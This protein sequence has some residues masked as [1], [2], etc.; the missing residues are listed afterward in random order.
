MLDEKLTE[1][2][3]K[4]RKKL[5]SL[6]IISERRNLLNTVIRIKNWMKL[7]EN[8]EASIII[9]LERYDKKDNDNICVQIGDSGTVAKDSV[10]ISKE[11]A[12]DNEALAS[13]YSVAFS[14]TNVRNEIVIVQE[15]D[16]MKSMDSFC[17]AVDQEDAKNIFVADTN[18]TPYTFGQMGGMLE[19]GDVRSGN[20]TSFSASMQTKYNNG[21]TEV[22]SQRETYGIQFA[23]H[24]SEVDVQIDARSQAK[25]TLISEEN[26]DEMVICAEPIMLIRN[27]NSI[28][29]RLKNAFK[30]IRLMS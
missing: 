15:N 5:L 9:D 23:D 30:T 4:I 29:E 18:F 21:F 2:C 26:V 7:D 27:K 13:E 22:I 6:V 8:V 14:S 19:S 20:P 10:T 11:L 12:I 1:W 16:E 3:M 17:Q 25:I 24:V 28:S